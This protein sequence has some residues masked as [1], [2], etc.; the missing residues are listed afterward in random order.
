MVR[1][2]FGQGLIAEFQR[3]LELARG[4]HG[5]DSGSQGVDVRSVFTPFAINKDRSPT[6]LMA[7]WGI[8]C[9]LQYQDSQDRRTLEPL[10]KLS[11][12]LNCT[13]DI[14]TVEPSS[15]W[16]SC[17]PEVILRLQPKSPRN[18]VFSHQ[19]LPMSDSEDHD[20]WLIATRLAFGFRQ[21]VRGHHFECPAS[22]LEATAMH[23]EKAFQQSPLSQHLQLE[24]TET[25]LR[26]P[27]RSESSFRRII[28]KHVRPA[29]NHDA[30][31]NEE[32]VPVDVHENAVSTHQENTTKVAVTKLFVHSLLKQTVFPWTFI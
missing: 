16:N 18:G 15:D 3:I 25:S 12:S 23:I 8:R 9:S 28:H 27:N 31:R 20:V 7:K 1:A 2:K 22:F 21:G 5:S 32:P 10:F 14:C 17:R 11:I 26:A 19:A 4:L 30:S 13:M 24:A 29:I 6:S